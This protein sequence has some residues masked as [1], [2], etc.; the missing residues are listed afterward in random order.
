MMGTL[1][2]YTSASSRPTLWPSF[3]RARARLTATVVLPTPPLPEATATRFFTPGMGWRSGIGCGA[4]PGGIFPR[5]NQKFKTLEFTY[6]TVFMGT[7]EA[8]FTPLH[9]QD[10]LCYLRARNSDRGIF[11]TF[12]RSRRGKDR[13]GQLWRRRERVSALPLERS[14]PDT[15]FLFPGAAACVPFRGR[16]RATGR[17]LRR[18]RERRRWRRLPGDAG[19]PAALDAPTAERLRWAGDLPSAPAH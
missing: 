13:C 5:I 18:K 15:A 2:P 3:W 1:E 14:P 6:K 12:C 8:R 7:P 17:E 10:W 11:C 4:D 16:K 9:S 19:Q